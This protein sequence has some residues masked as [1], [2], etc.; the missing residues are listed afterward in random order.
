[1]ILLLILLPLWLLKKEKV[2]GLP[3]EAKGKTILWFFI[4]P[5]GI[6]FIQPRMKAL[7]DAEK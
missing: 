7:L 6:F 4:F 2:L 3:G 1:M 5:V